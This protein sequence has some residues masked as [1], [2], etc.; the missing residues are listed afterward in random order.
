MQLKFH[1]EGWVYFV[2]SCLITII[3]IPFFTILGIFLLILSVY[4]FYFFRDPKRA[5]S[6]DDVV[7][8]P[9]DG[10]VTFIGSVDIRYL[11]SI[12]LSQNS[13]FVN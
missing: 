7:V 8:S 4:I 13:S 11:V 9:A 1:N 3:I 6:I 10:L 2:V 12:F 5:I